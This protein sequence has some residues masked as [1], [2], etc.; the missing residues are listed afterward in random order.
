MKNPIV[1]YLGIFI[2]IPLFLWGLGDYHRDSIFKETLSVL[3]LLAFFLMIGQFFLTRF[4]RKD[5]L[6]MKMNKVVKIHK[7]LGYIFI[8]IILLHPFFIV[9]S[10][11]FEAGLDVKEAFI[12]MLTTFDSLGIVLGIIAWSLLVI[13]GLLAFFRN[14]LGL[15]YRR[16][17]TI[18]GFVSVFFISIACWHV[19]DLG[20]HI[21]LSITVFV[22]FTTTLGVLYILRDYF[23]SLKK[24]KLVK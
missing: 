20:R 12:T 15:S 2:G 14:Q 13:L 3:T 10:R 4:F 7:L 11:Y 22:A 9:V 6:N 1:K 18:H 23:F 19:I 16:W 8:S 21:D 17:R 5:F 24:R